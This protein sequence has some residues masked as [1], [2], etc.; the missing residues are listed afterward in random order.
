MHVCWEAG[1][2]AVWQAGR[3]GGWQAGGQAG[4]QA[5]RQ[6]ACQTVCPAASLPFWGRVRARDDD[7]DVP[8]LL[9]SGPFELLGDSERACT[10]RI[11]FVLFLVCG[12][13]HRDKNLS[14]MQISDLPN[15][16]QAAEAQT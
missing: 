13:A 1:R 9:E 8:V 2:Q 7:D 14:E 6:L 11:S 5:G 15:G 4:W 16:N 10:P 12:R 3:L